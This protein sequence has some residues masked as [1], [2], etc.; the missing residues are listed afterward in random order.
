MMIE[1][2]TLILCNW[3]TAESIS[4]PKNIKKLSTLFAF[5]LSIN[6]SA[7][8]TIK[9]GVAL[10]F[11]PEIAS[12][13][14][15]LWRG[16]ELA[17]DKFNSEQFSKNGD[18][19]IELIKYPHKRETRSV[20]DV[21]KKILTD[22]VH[23]VV[24]GE[25][26]DE[27][28]SLGDAFQNKDVLLITP[29]ASNPRITEG[30][31]NV[32]RACFS[33]NQVAGRLAKWVANL[34]ESDSI[35]ILHHAGNIYS[36]YLSIEFMKALKSAKKSV[37]ISE[38]NYAGDRPDFTSAVRNFKKETVKLVVAFTG[39]ADLKAFVASAGNANFAPKYLGTDG[40]GSADAVYKNFVKDPKNGSFQAILTSYWQRE[41]KNV[42]VMQFMKSFEKQYGSN[43]DS[44]SAVAFDAATI[45]FR[46]IEKAKAHTSTT[47]FTLEVAKTMKESRFTDLTTSRNFKFNAS[48]SPDKT[49]FVYEVN[50]GGVRF[51]GGVE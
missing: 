30:R 14:N 13:N 32:F 23:F 51:L 24:G 21:A 3:K 1:S 45:L 42:A 37:K 17:R 26:S 5:F 46:S 10:L 35:G 44:A 33:D 8:E 6:V 47:D 34:K 48:N 7:V 15:S 12:S 9:V 28:I 19:K 16:I 40:W 25:L 39:P 43:P 50:Q 27:A 29:T 36:D 41:S 18:V 20:D 2:F 38:F 49:L 31:P 22:Q 4:M 11:T